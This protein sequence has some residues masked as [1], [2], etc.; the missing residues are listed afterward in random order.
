[1]LNSDLNIKAS[2]ISSSS[3]S[4]H[5]GSSYPLQIE[6]L[7]AGGLSLARWNGQVVLC[8]GGIPGET[9]QLEILSRRKGVTQGKILEIQEPADSRVVPICPVVGRCGGCQ[10]Q[11]VQYE[12]QLFQKRLILEDALRRIGKIPDVRISP[13]VPSPRPFGYTHRAVLPAPWPAQGSGR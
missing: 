8:A 2:R 3:E 5:F 13:V 11:H 6:K 9:V 7:V 4:L 1:M 12:E 10:L